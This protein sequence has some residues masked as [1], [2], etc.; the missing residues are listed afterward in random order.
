MARDSRGRFTKNNG[1]E[2][3]LALIFPSIKNI[4]YWIIMFIIFLPWIFILSK[5]DLFEKLNLMLEYLMIGRK[6]EEPQENG[7]KN[8]LFY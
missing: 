5:I 8:G 4:C 1:E 2:N 6:N 3:Q 7:K